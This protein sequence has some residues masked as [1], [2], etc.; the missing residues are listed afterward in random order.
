MNILVIEDEGELAGLL[1]RGL[2]AEG[3]IVTLAPDARTGLPLAVEG[4]FDFILL[5]LNLPVTGGLAISTAVRARGLSTPIIMVTARDTVDDRIAGLRQGAD[6]YLVKPFAFGELLA[7]I[8]AV[9]RRTRPQAAPSDDLPP[10]PD[11]LIH[12]DLTLDYGRKAVSVAGQPVRL[13]VKELDVLRLMVAHPARI[14]SRHDILRLVWGLDEDPLTNIVEVYISRLRR[15]LRAAGLD[16][17]D[18]VRGFGYRFEV[19]S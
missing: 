14:F 10:I 1:H 7:R 12:R 9:M 18:N 3:H 16:A 2:V 15:K 4:G 11:L 8:D 6:D 17:I 5:D 19:E 13:T